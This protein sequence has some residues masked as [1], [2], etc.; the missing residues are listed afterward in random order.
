MAVLSASHK[1]KLIRDYYIERQG[2]RFFW[3]TYGFIAYHIESQV[4][5]IDAMYI[6]RSHRNQGVCRALAESLIDT[7]KVCEDIEQVHAGVQLGLDSTKTIQAV[8]KAGKFVL[9]AYDPEE[10]YEYY[11][12]YL[13]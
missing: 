12:K 8:L 11:V 5:Q 2:R 6:D 1:L 9:D 3:G 7:M 13:T 10:D 4:L